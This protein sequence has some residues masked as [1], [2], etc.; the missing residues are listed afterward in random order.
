MAKTFF[1]L[2]QTR[3]GV[4]PEYLESKTKRNFIYSLPRKKV[5]ISYGNLRLFQI[6]NFE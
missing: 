6:R 1:K 4:F 2:E 5:T 3:H